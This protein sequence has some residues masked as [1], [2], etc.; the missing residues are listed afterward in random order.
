[1]CWGSLHTLLKDCLE[2]R[3]LDSVTGLA[4][5]V[6]DPQLILPN[7]P[8]HC[9]LMDL[10]LVHDLGDGEPPI[11]VHKSTPILSTGAEG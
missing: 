4:T 3:D 6:V 1:M 5:E 10:Q 7:L 8:P 9:L 11:S 2:I